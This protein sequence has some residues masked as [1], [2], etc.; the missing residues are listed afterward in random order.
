MLALC[1][2]ALTVGVDRLPGCALFF[3]TDKATYYGGK[4][5]EDAVSADILQHEHYAEQSLGD[6]GAPDDNLRDMEIRIASTN[7]NKGSWRRLLDFIVVAD[8]NVG[9]QEDRTVWTRESN[10]GRAP[11]LLV[12]GNKR[13]GIVMGIERRQSRWKKRDT[14]FSLLDDQ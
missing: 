9:C 4:E 8:A 2:C 14:V 1:V 13:I 6:S 12:V 3:S 5:G 10:V 7:V 11:A